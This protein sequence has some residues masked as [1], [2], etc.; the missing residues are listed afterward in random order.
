MLPALDKAIFSGQNGHRPGEQ[1]LPA[2]AVMLSRAFDMLDCALLVVTDEGRL[3]YANRPARALLKSGHGGLRLSG[4]ILSVTPAKVRDSLAEAIRLTCAGLQPG[5]LCLSQ[6]GVPPQNWLRIAVAPVYFGGAESK[7]ATHAAVW[8][9]NGAPP[10]PPD[11]ELL[12]ALFGLTRA[13]ARLSRALVSGCTAGEY[14]HRVGVRMATVRT[15]LHSIFV[16]TGVARQAELVALLSR[17][18]PLRLAAT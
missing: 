14:A 8:I 18:P 12:S 6:P 15:Q 5:G 17:V 9:V 13:E 2:L 7:G 10:A 4:G 3:D 16:K 1:Q 11:E